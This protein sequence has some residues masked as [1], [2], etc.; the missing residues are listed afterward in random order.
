MRPGDK[1]YVDP[2]SDA[3][4]N[5][6]ILI[7]SGEDEFVDDPEIPQ[8]GSD[9]PEEEGPVVDTGVQQNKD[10]ETDPGEGCST[11]RNNKKVTTKARTRSLTPEKTQNKKSS[12]SRSSRPRSRNERSSRR[13]RNKT[14]TRYDDSSD[15]S[16]RSGSRVTTRSRKLRKSRSKSDSRSGSF[17]SLSD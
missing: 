11:T 8:E 16:S 12:R 6:P 13:S 14:R 15:S 4:R 17:S 1:G 9:N 3:V 10:V 5:Q 7:N 2:R